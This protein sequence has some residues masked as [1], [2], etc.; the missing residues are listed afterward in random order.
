M[1]DFD[2]SKLLIIGIVALVFIPS[3]DLPRVLR[4]IGQFVGKM[5]RMASEFQGQFMDA[6]READMTELRREAEKLSKAAQ[7]TVGLD[8]VHDLNT[9]LTVAL[10]GKAALSSS[11]AAVLGAESEAA[12]VHQ[13]EANTIAP[14][15]IAEARLEAPHEEAVLAAPP[16]V[17]PIPVDLPS[18]P[19][20][21]EPFVH[22]APSVQGVPIIEPEPHVAREPTGAL[23][24]EPRG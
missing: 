15:H 2:A 4:Q 11:E 3:K 17:D 22:G 8:R 21:R 7:A 10:E 18:A 12:T 19:A 5:R 9:E 20:H 1:F 24:S 23:T 13:A 6:M 14:P 16:H